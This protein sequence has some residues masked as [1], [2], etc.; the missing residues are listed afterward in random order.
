MN[1]RGFLNR[2]D[3]VQKSLPFKL[4][5]SA[6]VLILAISAFVVYLVRAEAPAAVPDVPA[7]A[8]APAQA[9]GPGAAA[10]GNVSPEQLKAAEEARLSAQRAQQIVRNLAAARYGYGSI[11]IGLLALTAVWLIIIWLGICLTYLGL[12]ILGAAIAYPMSLSPATKDYAFVIVGVVLL[13]QAFTA[14]IAALRLLLSDNPITEFLSALTRPAVSPLTGKQQS[15]LLP[16]PTDASVR[17]IALKTVI[18]ALRMKVSLIFIIILILALAALPLVLDE[19]TPLRYRVQSFLQWGTGG[20][21]WIIAVLTL[22]F[23]AASVAFEQRDRQIWQTMTKPVSAAQYILGKWL[24]VI[25][26]NA[27]LLGV[28]CTGILLFTEYLRTLPAEGEQARSVTAANEIT[29]DRL[30]LE[31]QVLQARIAVE[32]QVTRGKSDPEFIETWVRPYIEDGQKRDPN[33]GKDQAT[34]DRIVDDL[35][36]QLVGFDRSIPPGAGRAFLFKGLG[37][38]K[39]QNKLL[40]IRY[41]IDAG[42]NEPDKLYT[43]TFV[44]GGIPTPPQSVGLGPTHT[45]PINPDII[46]DEGNLAMEVYNA[47]VYFNRDGTV[48]VEPNEQTCQFPK[49]GL[50]VSYSVGSFR[51]NFLRVSFILWVKLAFLAMLAITAATCLSFPVACL[52]AFSVFLCA[53]GTAF[54][55]NSLEY[56]DAVDT[57]QNVVYWK[58]AIRGVGLWI[59]WIFKTYSEL[60]PTERLVDGRL[61]SWGGVAWG[62]SLLAVW[63][64]VLYGVAVLIFRRRELAT[65]SGQ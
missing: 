63:S 26:V 56:Y 51:G 25:C 64:L 53:E 23:S 3:R 37:E 49:G 31:S 39:K 29:Y 43:I 34:Y 7:A 2:C 24:G 50:E 8:V 36:K 13:A 46:D 6:L 57:G 45:M 9:P 33:F 4:A 58:V 12:S 52:V 61:L 20:S 44:F 15:R 5:A 60:K 17:G 48:V 30:I 38:A 42:S 32:P 40:T 11:A 22:I 62:A 16:L 54:L 55:S 21:F 47:G 35:Y 59:T 65:Y 18:E 1:L 28:C 27:V 14:F 19:K 41:R 10:V